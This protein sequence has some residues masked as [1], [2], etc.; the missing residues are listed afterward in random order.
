MD[1]KKIDMYWEQAEWEVKQAKEI[2][3]QKKL[4]KREKKEREKAVHN[5]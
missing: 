1:K 5:N 4:K 2:K 3:E